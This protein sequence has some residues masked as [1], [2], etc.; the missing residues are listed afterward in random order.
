M[1]K[2]AVIL[3]LLVL[4]SVGAVSAQS[5]GRSYLILSSGNSL[6]ANLSAQVAGAGGVITRVMPEIGIAV[7]TSANPNFARQIRGVQSVVPNLSLDWNPNE[8]RV[9]FVEEAGN[10]PNS[11]NDDTRF[12]LQYGHDAVNAPEAW[13][14]GQRGQGAVVAVL[15]EGFDLDHPDLASQIIGQVSFVPLPGESASA[16]YV[17]NDPFSHGSHVA[18]TIAAADNAFG[19]IGVAP[20][21]KLVLVKV[22]SEVRGSGEFDWIIAGILYAANRGDVDV[23]NMSLGGTL[24]KNGESG[25]DGYTAREAQELRN[26]ISRATA[27]AY[28]RGITVLVSEGNSAIDKDHTGPLITLPADA[29]HVVS[30]AATTAIGWATGRPP[31]GNWDGNFDIPTSYTNFGRSAVDFASVGGDTLYPGNEACL[32]GGLVRPCWVFDLVFSVGSNLNPGVASYYWSGGTSMAA[33][34]V[35]GVAALIV[36]EAGGRLHPAQVERELRARA[37][38]GGN[39][40]FYGKGVVTSGY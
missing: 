9:E 10:P 2:I 30:V 22:L 5:A 37:R 33:P 34:H 26:A 8:T 31:A 12:D 1:K 40:P 18:G 14:A 32:V 15:D 19:T 4:L 20:S 36:G 27:Y 29:S 35:S 21:A 24:F 39:S 38:Y 16:T 6:P 11:G 13:A 7:A 28:Q 17:L 23:I 25:P 3:V